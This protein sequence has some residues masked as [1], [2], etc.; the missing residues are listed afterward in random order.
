MHGLAAIRG[1]RCA[2]R[3]GQVWNVHRRSVFTT[4]SDALSH[5]LPQ[6]AGPVTATF[7]KMTVTTLPNGARVITET[8]PY[9]D[10]A[11]VGVFIKAGADAE[12]PEEL[13]VSHF[14]DRLWFH[15]T[16]N[17]SQEETQAIV[18][19]IG[20]MNTIAYKQGFLHEA[21]IFEPMLPK[22][23]SLTCDAL[24]CPAYIDDEV[25]V[26]REF[27]EWDIETQD[28]KASNID[29]LVSTAA[30]KTGP[31]N[32]LC[33]HKDRVNKIT[34]ADI[35]KF[36]KRTFVGSNVSIGAIGLDH[37]TLL[38]QAIAAGL[39]DLPAGGSVVPIDAAPEV[40]Y[41][42]R[43]LKTEL[44]PITEHSVGP[45]LSKVAVG[46]QAPFEG[47][48]LVVVSVIRSLLGGGSAF[49]S[50]GPGK[51]L[52][53][54]LYMSLISNSFVINDLFAQMYYSESGGIM[55]IWGS[56]V[57]SQY[58]RSNGLQLLVD[59]MAKEFK[60]LA[61]PQSVGSE[62]LQRAKNML[63]SNVLMNLEQKP[64]AVEDMLRQSAMYNKRYTGKDV[65]QAVDKVTVDDVR[66]VA[67]EMLKSRPCCALV[68]EPGDEA[69]SLAA[70]DAILVGVPAPE[71]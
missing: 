32:P 1:G 4:S 70:F 57:G 13:G 48:D 52:Y 8:H 44:G 64:M 29:D 31:G 24:R 42:P 71:R 55:Y 41:S 62:E 51:G 46:F 53:S 34:R 20:T 11:S 28:E 10:A 15:S 37:E 50:G 58:S 2:L 47:Q 3:M 45:R 36:T 26:A 19:E 12:R 54:R 25:D 40:P 43:L 63:K 17:R 21:T 69:T 56:A 22:F 68:A 9:A 66:R 65:C 35:L 18:D 61:H 30:Y 6:A 33:C 60:R 39:G 5:P 59:V 23:L 16:A 38:E 27:V 67:F 49:M 14:V 7:E